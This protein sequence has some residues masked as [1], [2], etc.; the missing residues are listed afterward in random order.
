M[1]AR[2]LLG[3][4]GLTLVLC[5]ALGDPHL[6]GEVPFSVVER[7]HFRAL[8]VSP[9]RSAPSDEPLVVHVN[10]VGDGADEDLSK[11]IA[12]LEENANVIVVPD[13]RGVPLFLTRADLAATSGRQTLGATIPSG[14]AAEVDVPA[15]G[16]CV[17]AH[18]ILHFI[19]LRH[20]NDRA[21]I[22]YQHCSRGFLDRAELNDAQ[23]DQIARVDRIVATTPSGV[24][25]WAERA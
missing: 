12:W 20:V 14:M 16:D 15:I 23:R 24:Q 13:P 25:V 8:A 2:L 22:M 21:N 11:P 1:R 17:V 7:E 9:T 4:L 6:A 10:L 18:E 5:G 19:G 3:V